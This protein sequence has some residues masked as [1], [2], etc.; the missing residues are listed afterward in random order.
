VTGL[1]AVLGAGGGIGGEIVRTLAKAGRPVRAVARRSLDLPGGVEQRNADL[2][3]VKQIARAIDGA[4]I[5]YHCAMPA[6]NRW[7]QEFP[8]MTRA[9]AD[10]TA[11]VGAALV[12]ADNLYAA[13]ASG[14]PILEEDPPA[15]HGPKARTRSK[16]ANE[17]LARDDLRVCLGR[18]ADYYGPGARGLNS[19][20]GI[21]LFQRAITGRGMR[22]PG[23]LDEPHTL[24]HLPDLARALVMLADSESAW[25]KA[26]NLPSPRPLT[27][28]E[29]AAAAAGASHELKVRALPKIALRAAG[30]L[31]SEARGVSEVFWQFDRPFLVD[32]SAFEAQIGHLALTPHTKAVA[33]TIASHRR[34]LAKRATHA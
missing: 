18:A 26:W 27:G 6:Y 13:P 10:A 3:D 17:L 29:Y 31:N 8:A 16:T 25:G 9:I 24:H 5:V 15:D 23:K 21:T 33:Q 7:P 28:R 32:S 14:Y 20:P 22:W 1:H 34:G 4:A 19:I 2:R 30:L 11:S 12:V